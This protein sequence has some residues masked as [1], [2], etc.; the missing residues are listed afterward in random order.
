MLPSGYRPRIVLLSDGQETSGDAVAAARSLNARGIRV[1]V[2]PVV[3]PSGPEVLV[4][5][6]ST[7]PTVSEGDRFSIGVNLSANTPTDATVHVMVNGQPM[8]D[9]TVSLSAGST[10][11][12]FS[13]QAPQSGLLDVQASV[14]A[15]A[16]TL[17]PEQRRALG[18]RSRG[19]TPRADRGTAPGRRRRDRLRPLEHRHAPG[20]MR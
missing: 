19:P 15:S 4:D 17:T 6:V 14:D 10:D 1:D 11:L 7:P 13:A 5:S 2:M 8:A 9:Q 18:R 3:P 12:S 20:S 16:D